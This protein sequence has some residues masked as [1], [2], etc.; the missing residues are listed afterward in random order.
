MTALQFAANIVDKT[1]RTV[2]E[3]R[4][5]LVVPTVMIVEGVLNGELVPADEIAKFP[6]AWDGRPFVIGHPQ[7]GDDSV[8]ANTPEMLERYAAGQ[9]FGTEFVDGKLKSEIWVDVARTMK[10][11]GGPEYIRRV[12]D[13]KP[14]EVSTGYFRELDEVSGSW[15]GEQHVGIARDLRPDHLAAL[16]D[17][18]GACSWEDGC[19]CPRVNE[20][21]GFCANQER[22]DGIMV[23]L[24]LSQ[25]TAQQIAIPGGEPAEELHVTLAFLG[26]LD[27][28]HNANLDREKL[29]GLLSDFARV[30]KPPVGKIGGIG[31][32]ATVEGDGHPTY[33][34]FDSVDLS[35]LRHELIELLRWSDFP[36]ART[37][38]F[39]PHITLA[40]TD[41]M[42]PMAEEQEAAISALTLKIG[43]ER[44]DFPFLD[45]A[46]EYNAREEEIEANML[47]GRGAQ[48]DIPEAAKTS[49]QATAR[50][51]LEKEFDVE[52]KENERRNLVKNALRTLASALGINGNDISQEDV[53]TMAKSKQGMVDELCERLELNADEVGEGLNALSV[54]TLR[55]ILNAF[56]KPDQEPEEEPEEKEPIPQEEASDETSDEEPRANEQPCADKRFEAMERKIA[57]LEQRDADLTSQLER[58]LPVVQQHQEAQASEK[59]RLVGDLA[60]NER[61]AFDEDELKQMDVPQLRKFARSL[62]PASYAGQEGGVAA[63]KRDDRPVEIWKGTRRAKEK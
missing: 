1:Y 53:E 36:V 43:N 37:H 21:S 29:T 28:P 48:A 55:A 58:A 39:T 14:V 38:G 49:A 34:H 42:P 46:I 30:R 32:F 25:E 4:E 26:G 45:Q 13:G 20:C 10:I 44:L 59:A 15:K 7:Q 41:E 17:S 31:Q 61:C 5:W 11:P 2:W 63:N 27:D 51:L 22:H 19:G 3:G 62:V 8:S 40:Y 57:A 9:I 60:S 35:E 24:F 6:G 18:V 33:A 23:A 16:L 47:G 56:G 50:R 54:T 12:K 52:P